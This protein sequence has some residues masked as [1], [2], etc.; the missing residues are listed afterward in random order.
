MIVDVEHHLEPKE[1]WEKCGGKLGQTVLLRAPDGTILRPL[2]DASWD[3]EIHLKNMDIAGI[4]MTVLSSPSVMPLEEAKKFND[5]FASI[6]KKYPKRFAAFAVTASLGGKQAFDELDRSINELGLKGVVITAQIGGKPLDSRELWPFYKK[7]AQLNVPIFVHPSLKP[8]GFDALEG[9]Y[10]LFRSI[11]R[12]FDLCL[13][14]LRLCVGGVLEEFPDLKFVIAHFGG[15]YSTIKE[16]MDR[17]IRTMGASFWYQ[18]PLI[19]EPYLENYNKYFDRLYFNMAGREIGLQTTKAALTNIS[20]M[21]LMFGTD[22][23]PN[24]SNDAKGMRTYIEEIRKLDLD[25]K[26]IDAMLGNNAVELFRLK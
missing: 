23:P 18:K 8:P 20:P 6:A 13:A 9:P 3:V 22:Y 5:H 25:K 10:D 12:E 16:R 1:S 19:S 26:L 15:G 2:D 7:V 4:D 17:Y 24:F 11:G 21:R 14:T